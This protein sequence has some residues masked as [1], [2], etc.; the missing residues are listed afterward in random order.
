MFF[1]FLLLGCLFLCGCSE[2]SNKLQSL[3]LNLYNEPPTLDLRKATDTTSMNILLNLFEGLTR[4]G[5]DQQPHPAVAEKIEISDDQLTYTFHLREC[6]WSNG[7]PVTTE[8]FLHSWTK[9]IDSKFPSPFAYKLYVIKNGAAIKEGSLPMEALGVLAPDAKTLI[10]TLEHPAPYFL[11]LLSFPTFFPINKSID[12]KSEDWPA[13]AGPLFVSNGP[14]QLKSWVHESELV[15]AKNPSYWDRDAVNLDEIHFAM[16][17]DTMTEFYMYEMGELDW[18]GSPLSNL[19]TEIVPSLR[20]KGKLFS[21]PTSGVY[22]YK[23]NTDTPLGKNLKIRQALGLAVNRQAIVDHILQA[24]QLPATGLVPRMPNWEEEHSYFA[25]GNSEKARQLFQKGLDELGLTREQLMPV[26]LSFNSNREHQK[27]AQA[28]QHQWKQTLGFRTEL[29]TL[30]WKVYLSKVNK[31]N[32]EIARM[33]WVADYSDPLSF[34]EPYK[35]RDNPLHG[36]NNETGWEH[37]EY[38]SLLDAAERETDATQR[39]A[40][41]FEAEKLLMSEMPIIPIYYIICSCLKKPYVQDVHLSPL[42]TM[43]LKWAKIE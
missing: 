16:I 1:R 15:L 36:G 30:D 25:D 42:G 43:D 28:I 2:P 39:A 33:S 10:V 3:R 12:E 8:D 20:E 41:L 27:V 32:Y 37:P 19:P 9:T 4:V 26:K 35:Y 24:N 31:Q 34:L 11:E 6:C 21:Y 13:E 18:A 7:D 22:C 5:S 23:I 14:Y 38:I 17:D 40:L 29:E